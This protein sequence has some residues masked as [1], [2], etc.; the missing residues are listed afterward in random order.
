VQ[1]GLTGDPELI[2]AFHA[3]MSAPR[4]SRYLD[5]AGGD[6][7]TAI[8][9]YRWNALLAQSLHVYVQGWEVCLR[10][11]LDRFLSNR[12]GADWP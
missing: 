6:R 9:L 8:R 5:L 10:N 7:T 4:I 1:D 11:K 2:H 12:Y 3:S